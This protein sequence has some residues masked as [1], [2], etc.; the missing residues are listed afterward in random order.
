MKTVVVTPTYNERGNIKEFVA[1][2]RQ[3][4]PG[5]HI[6]IVDDNS[7]DGTGRIADRLAELHPGEVHVLHRERKQ[8]LGRA[9]VAGFERALASGYDILVQMDADLS[10][11]PAFL[12][13]MLRRIENCDLVLGSRYT[14]GVAVVNWDLKRLIL[15]KSANRYVQI[16]AGI[17]ATDAT[18]GFKCWRR[19][20]LEA[21]GL[22]EVFSNGYMFQIEMTTKAIKMGFRVEEEPIVFYER[23]LGR[24]KMDLPIICEALWRVWKLRFRRYRRRKS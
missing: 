5:I 11:D 2:V 14:R 6:L 21:I 1:R 13:A 12:P 10:H 9:Y 15:S 22:S 4:V 23:N 8:G 17:P 7:P 20:T 16:V 19:E 24:S 3:A 18:G